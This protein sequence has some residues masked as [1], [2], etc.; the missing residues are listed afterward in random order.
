MSQLNVRIY[1]KF[2][3]Y[4]NWM[5]STIG[6]GAGEFAVALIPSGDNT[7]LTPPA[8]GIKVG[9]DGVKK[10]SEL[11]WIQAV[12]GDVHSWAKAAVKPEYKASEIKEL[13]QFI[14]GEIQDTNTTYAFSY[15]DGKITIKHK[16]IDAEEFSDLTVLDMTATLAAKADKV[17]GGV[18]GNLLQM[19]ASGNLVDSGKKVADFAL[20]SDLNT[21]NGKISAL[22]EKVGNE[23]VNKQ[24]TDAITAQ[25]QTDA[26]K[27]ATQTALGTLETNVSGKFTEVE[28]NVSKNAGDIAAIK[29]D[30]GTVPEDKTI[31]QMIADAQ[32]AATYDDSD[33]QT[34]MGTAEG[35]ITK[36]IGDDADK[37]VRTIA[38]EE[39][40]KQLIP[41]NAAESLN[42]LQEIAAWIQAHPGDAA[43]MNEQIQSNKEAIENLETAATEHLIHENRAV[44]DGITAEKVAAWDKA[45]ENVIESIEGVTATIADKKATITEV[46][47][48]LLK[49]DGTLIFNC[50]TAST[51]I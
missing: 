32:T 5:N 13:E 47:V 48:E 17:V 25:A 3:T 49:S 27:Y 8:V 37:S 41:E 22:E 28:G 43:A 50:G 35:K 14:A 24:I 11:P 21:A 34:R 6:L 23:T 36:L 51:V 1:N 12:A 46:P 19:D 20:A 39:L 26:A 30:I 18:A 4:E 40:A 7:G 9:E 2:D 33:L 31:V 42:E 15:A 38:N 29:E 45:Q 10:F 16:E 44:L